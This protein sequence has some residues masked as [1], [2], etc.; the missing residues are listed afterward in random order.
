MSLCDAVPQWPGRWNPVELSVPGMEF[1]TA[2]VFRILLE[3]ENFRDNTGTRWG[4]TA[5]KEV[6]PPT[7]SDS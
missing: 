2:I 1:S 3:A 7:F 4:R 6:P 5:Q